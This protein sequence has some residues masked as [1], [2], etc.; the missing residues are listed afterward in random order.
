MSK[1]SSGE[2]LVSMFVLISLALVI[3]DTY[4][5]NESKPLPEP[6]PTK[7]AVFDGY[8]YWH[9]GKEICRVPEPKSDDDL[10]PA[11]CQKVKVYGER[12][13]S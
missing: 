10:H 9:N 7:S 11:I 12:S 4:T 1:K 6:E 13:E 3:V 2:L 5:T 8:V